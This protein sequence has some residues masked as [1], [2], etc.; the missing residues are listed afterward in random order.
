MPRGIP[1][2]R[3][4]QTPGEVAVSA[5]MPADDLAEFDAPTIPEAAVPSAQELLAQIVALKGELGRVKA[6]QAA[7]GDT[8]TQAQDGRTEVPT[9]VARAMQDADVKAGRRPRAILTPQGWLTH[10]ESART[11]GSLGNAPIH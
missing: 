3:T 4:V 9:E 1:R 5:D 11:A 6:A 10:P 2:N 8:P 7:A